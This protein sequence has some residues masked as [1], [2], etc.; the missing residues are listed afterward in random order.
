MGARWRVGIGWWRELLAAEAAIIARASARFVRA[1]LEG[2]EARL[3]QGLR[4]DFGIFGGLGLGE[5]LFRIRLARIRVGQ[6]E[7][8][9]K[10]DVTLG[11]RRIL[12]EAS[13]VGGCAAV[14]HGI[15]SR[16]EDENQH[17][18]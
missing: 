7:F 17:R 18:Q 9:V 5:G 11:E 12:A 2:N 6:A 16:D 15:A 13:H 14:L 10:A 8:K 1:R 3:G 4:D